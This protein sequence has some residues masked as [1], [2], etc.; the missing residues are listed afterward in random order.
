MK[1]KLTYDVKTVFHFTRFGIRIHRELYRS[2]FPNKQ[3]C[4]YDEFSFS[5][6]YI[7][8]KTF[9]PSPKSVK[10]KERY[11]IL[12][13]IVIRNIGKSFLDYFWDLLYYLLS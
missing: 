7:Y 13:T 12:I 1:V 5:Y 2:S 11:H 6:F 3:Y 10:Y 9:L 8:P 4:K